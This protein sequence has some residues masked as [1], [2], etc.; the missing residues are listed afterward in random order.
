[1]KILPWRGL[2]IRHPRL[3]R[4]LHILAPLVF[5]L[6]LSFIFFGRN[7]SWSKYY[8]GYSTDSVVTIWF[9]NW[10]SFAI[11]HGLNPFLC[12]YVWF[13][14]GYNF[15][16]ATSVP[17][18]AILSWPV[19]VLGSPVLSYNILMLS[20]PAFGAW[21]AFLLGRELTRDW[22][23]SLVC[24]FLFGFSAPE[25]WALLANLNL[26]TVVLIPLAILLCVRRLRG[27]LNRW[28]FVVLLSLLL[29]AQLGISTEVLATLCLI[30]ALSWGIFL[31]F[32]PVGERQ[33]FWRLAAD[34][35]L[36][37]P[38]VMILASF[39]LYYLVKGLP[40][41]P[42]QINPP[43]LGGAELLKF[44]V[45]AVPIKP[46]W[47]MLAAIAR[48]F[49]GFMP[50]NYTYISP[51]LLLLL[52][53]Y[54]YRHISTAYVKA[55]LALICIISVLSLGAKLLFNG[56]LTNIP[57]PWALFSHI[58][59]IRSIIPNRLLIYL[60]LGS[61][62]AAAFFLTEARTVKSRL[63]RFALAGLACLC[64]S[65]AKVDVLPMP[66]Q[67]QPIFQKQT[68]FKWSR[69]PED[70]FFTPAH[71]KKALGSMPNVILLPDPSVGPGMAW[72]V[73]AGFGFTQAAGYV[74][75]KLVHEQKW[76]VLDDTVWGQVKP[77]FGA[78]FP[79][80][81]AAHRVDYILIGPG[82]PASVISAIEA[83]GWPHRMDSGIEIVKT[84]ADLQ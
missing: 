16:W 34:I 79:A 10:W 35:A 19:T 71:I 55:L 64:L 36:S 56:E 13:P 31:L 25:L 76:H 40:D 20:A 41:V 48:Q 39:F 37:A 50:N 54:F 23:A 29:V 18:L 70:P 28:Q 80:F 52:V 51:P 26:D 53:L 62:I 47:M 7:I 46:D 49:S 1:M 78:V 30:G 33:T 84:P 3:F 69:W 75:F 27:S 4:W 72:Q 2:P 73:N 44:V 82:T 22:A 59:I 63:S 77:D 15:T 42:A 9:L 11:S 12:K 68:E 58:P 17:F 5:Y 81:C 74:G 24:G 60:S 6:T 83:L 66:W 32:T 45:P 57:M 38:L 65:P 21:A 14:A 61:A 67:T 43:G 8:F